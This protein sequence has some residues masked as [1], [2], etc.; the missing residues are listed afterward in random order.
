VTDIQDGWFSWS[1]RT[2]L[3]PEQLTQHTK[4]AKLE[5]SKLLI[6]ICD[7][8]T[9]RTLAQIHRYTAYPEIRGLGGVER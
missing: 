7:E 2:L 3:S 8:I 1:S 4:N 6:S 5:T 9:P